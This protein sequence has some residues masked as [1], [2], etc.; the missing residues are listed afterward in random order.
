MNSAIP[1]LKKCTSFLTAPE[2]LGWILIGLTQVMQPNLNQSQ[3]PRNI[4]S[5][6]PRPGSCTLSLASTII[7]TTVSLTGTTC[8]QSGEVFSKRSKSVMVKEKRFQADKTPAGH[9]ANSWEHPINLSSS[10]TYFSI[11]SI[12]AAIVHAV[13]SKMFILCH[14]L[15]IFHNTVL[16]TFFFF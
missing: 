11:Q 14:W 4:V 13:E 6:L 16:E 10:T 1:L 9:C 5:S 8:T 2:S 3:E 12:R 7:V 15:D